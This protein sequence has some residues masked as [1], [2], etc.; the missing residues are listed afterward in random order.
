MSP[1]PRSPAAIRRR[2][3]VQALL[4]GACVALSPRSSRAEARL[5]RSFAQT[6]GSV[7]SRA[8]FNKLTQP[9]LRPIA[10]P[11][12]P[13]MHAIWGSTGRDDRGHIW[14]GVA[15]V[16]DHFSGHLMEYDPRTDKIVDRGDVLSALA[17][18]RPLA[19]GEGQIKIHTKF[20]QADDG[21]LYFAST[22]EQ[23]E[24][25]D[26]SHPGKWGGHLWRLQP[27]EG[28]T[29]PV[30]EHLAAV[31]EGLTCAGGAGR[32]IYAL[33]LWNHVLYRFDTKTGDLRRIE[34]GAVPGHMCRNLIVDGR[35]HVYVPRV[36]FG[37]NGMEAS[38][39]EFGPDLFEIESTPLL[40][41]ADGQTPASGH[42]IIG[43]T[44]LADESVVFATGC[45]HLY[46]ITPQARGASKVTALGWIHPKGISY[47]PCLFVWDGQASIAA[48]GQV[49]NA[50]WD[51][52]VFDLATG[53]SQTIPFPQHLADPG[54]VLLYGT[55]TK[56]DQGAFYVVGRYHASGGR[57]LPVILQ[58]TTV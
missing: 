46:K 9:R 27:T 6:T 20:I 21:Y 58:V 22:D 29:Q 57:R 41:Y 38:L 14:F 42:G 4:A 48:V 25:E 26:G 13:D 34:V 30:W 28:A 8:P 56:D 55:H 12:F 11:E 10:I 1:L 32:W 45:G 2:A 36:T 54:S 52:I 37:A 47:T 49:P 24:A 43:F 3:A 33:G 7:F 15:A 50:G 19:P 18:I 5:P 40:H 35:G 16:N 31:R 44:F 23:D 17:K 39:V 51:W 53:T